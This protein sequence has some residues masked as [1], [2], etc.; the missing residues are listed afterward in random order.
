MNVTPA[1]EQMSNPTIRKGGGKSWWDFALL[2]L[3]FWQHEWEMGCMDQIPT[4]RAVHILSADTNNPGGSAAK[5][6]TMCF[7][8]L[9][10]GGQSCRWRTERT[11]GVLDFPRETHINATLKQSVPLTVETDGDLLIDAATLTCR[12]PFQ[13]LAT[14]TDSSFADC[15]KG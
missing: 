2:N 4:V 3:V 9:P 5:Q 7:K 14:N 8:S 6:V 13:S 1:Y 11:V 12:E 10:D 15:V